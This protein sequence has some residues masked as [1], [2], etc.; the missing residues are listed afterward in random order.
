MIKQSWMTIVAGE[1]LVD[2][3]TAETKARCAWTGRGYASESLCA[4]QRER[5]GRGILGVEIVRSNYGH[6]VRY[7]SG[8][9]GWGILAG[10]RSGQLDGTLEDA[11]RYAREWVARDPARRYAWRRNAA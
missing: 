9:Q 8:L 5:S 2:T 3:M 1:A 4:L 6:T 11:E 10:C 7:D